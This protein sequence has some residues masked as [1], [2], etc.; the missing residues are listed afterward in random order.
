MRSRR[1]RNSATG[2]DAI[3]LQIKTGAARVPLSLHPVLAHLF[4]PNLVCAVKS[5]Y[6]LSKKAQQQY[7][8]FSDD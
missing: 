6:P 5:G 1:L 4:M 3:G 7:V 8:R 2:C